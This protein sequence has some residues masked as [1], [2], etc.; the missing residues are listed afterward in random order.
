MGACTTSWLYTLAPVFEEDQG[1]KLKSS[2]YVVGRIRLQE[3][4]QINDKLQ[5][6]L[7]YHFLVFL[8]QDFLNLLNS[9]EHTFSII[10]PTRFIVCLTSA[11]GLLCL[12]FKG[13]KF[14]FHVS[15]KKRSQKKQ[16]YKE[17]SWRNV[18]K[19]TVLANTPPKYSFSS[20]VSPDMQDWRHSTWTTWQWFSKLSLFHRAIKIQ[21]LNYHLI[22]EPC[23][24]S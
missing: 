18:S 8:F 16:K 21:I 7:Q 4:V 2:S 14:T 11:F 17:I 20:P 13:S 1:W 15:G 19:W 12:F 6:R 23:Y 5:L 3:K 24:L 10:T 22:E 9:L